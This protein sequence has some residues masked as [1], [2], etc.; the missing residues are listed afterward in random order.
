MRNS[1]AM[2]SIFIPRL[3]MIGLRWL[4]G[5][6]VAM[7]MMTS[8]IAEAATCGPEPVS[9]IVA[10]STFHADEGD[11]SSTDEETGEHKA[12]AH[13]HCHHGTQAIRETAAS[14]AG[15]ELPALHEISPQD[16]A[17]SAYEFGLKRPPRA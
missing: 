5:F 13:G 7:M 14:A 15:L 1:A 4:V 10:G 3:R 16:R 8:A 9:D 17:H 2:S 6:V 12:C 11:R